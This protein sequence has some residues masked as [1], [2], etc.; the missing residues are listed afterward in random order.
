MSYIPHLLIYLNIYLI[1]ALSLNLVVG[2]CGL[3]TLAHAGYFALGSYVYA[4]ST[5]KLH[6]NFLSAS[7]LAIVIPALLSGLVSLPAWRLKGNFFVLVSL[8]IQALMFSAFYNWVNLTNGPLGLAGIAKPR[9]AGL[10]LTNAWSI[11]GLMTGMTLVCGTIVG[12]LLRSPWGRLLQAVRDDEL[13]AQSL[14]KPTRWIKVQVL[15]IACG[16]VGLAGAMYGAYVGYVD[17]SLASLDE[18]ILMLSMVIVGGVGNV[19]GP[20]VGAA[21]LLA[22]PEVLR[23]AMLPESVAANVRLLLYGVLLVVMMHARPQGLAGRYRV[24]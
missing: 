11:L 20:M 10:V 2:Y 4:L 9:L 7:A 13:A 21:V 15:A 18:S 16:M 3:L 5:L 24:E 19:L 8:A 12:V 1:V 6:C 22:I 14:G 23:W 17:P